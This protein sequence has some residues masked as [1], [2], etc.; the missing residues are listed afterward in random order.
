MYLEKINS[1]SDLKTLNIDQLN[2]LSQ[3]IRDFLIKSL[4]KTGGHL[5]SNL[6]VVELTVALNY[7]FDFAKDKIVWDVGH[8][9]YTHKILTGRKEFFD[10]LRKQ[11]GLSGFPKT[12]ESIYD[13]FNTGHSSTSISA[14]LGF[15]TARDLLGKD[16][17]VVSVIGDGAMTGG[18]VYEAMNNTGANNKKHL[19][20]LNDNQMSISEN[21]GSMACQSDFADDRFTVPG[22]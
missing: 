13:H 1:P 18:L 9:C 5:A 6:G 15:A 12:E 3:E 17:N 20:I 16:Y 11:D 22:R 19:I 14:S 21:V 7:C 4:S 10:N 8:Q 2:V